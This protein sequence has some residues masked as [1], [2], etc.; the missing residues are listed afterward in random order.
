M[1]INL[2]KVVGL[3]AKLSKITS[4][5]FKD[6]EGARESRDGC[7]TADEAYKSNGAKQI[8]VIGCSGWLHSLPD[9][10]TL[11]SKVSFFLRNGA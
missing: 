2:S 10:C 6:V 3:L 11:W 7:G 9:F 1:Q 8:N 5:A 4:Q